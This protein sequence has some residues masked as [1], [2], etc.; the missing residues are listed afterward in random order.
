MPIPLRV[1]GMTREA[2]D[3]VHSAVSQKGMCNVLSLPSF[4]G[5]WM[6]GT[7]IKGL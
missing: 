2:P 3:A 7:N 5:L 4:F 1:F 6:T